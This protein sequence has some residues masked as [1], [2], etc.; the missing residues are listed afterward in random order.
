MK[1]IKFSQNIFH[2][3]KIHRLGKTH[4]C[5][6]TVIFYSFQYMFEKYAF[7]ILQAIKKVNIR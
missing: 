1:K 3:F 2:I 7:H 5:Q 4:I 6:T